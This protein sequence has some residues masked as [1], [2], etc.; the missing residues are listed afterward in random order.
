ME[1]FL[2]ESSS[3]TRLGHVAHFSFRPKRLARWRLHTRNYVSDPMLSLRLSRGGA[4]SGCLAVSAGAVHYVE[5]LEILLLIDE[6]IIL[7]LCIFKYCIID[8][9]SHNDPWGSKA[10]IACPWPSAA[11]A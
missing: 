6:V 8:I 3:A 5:A 11:H 2:D 9:L 1:S 4:Y 7:F 10:R